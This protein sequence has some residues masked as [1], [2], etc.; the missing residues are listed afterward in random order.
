MAALDE[1]GGN[2]A[3]LLAVAPFLKYSGHCAKVVR[4][5]KM[6]EDIPAGLGTVLLVL[7]SSDHWSKI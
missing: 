2:T 1:G 3:H 4:R 6:G 5:R 7:W